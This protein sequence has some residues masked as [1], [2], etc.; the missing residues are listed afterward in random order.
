MT[1]STVAV[2]GC[3]IA[4]LL[5][6]FLYHLKDLCAQQP[7]EYDDMNRNYLLETIWDSYKPTP[8]KRV[9]TFK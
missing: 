2:T 6:L 4:S 5:L 8:E 7:E 1:T 9:G 3:R